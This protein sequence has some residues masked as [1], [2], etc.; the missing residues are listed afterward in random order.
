[1]I[2]TARLKHGD[3]AT[4][5]PRSQSDAD[6]ASRFIDCIRDAVAHYGEPRTRA[7][8]LRCCKG[9]VAEDWIAGVSDH[10][11]VLLRMSCNNWITILE[12]DFM[13][14]LASRLSAARAETFHWNLGRTPAEYVAKK[15]RLLRMANIVEDDEVVG[16]LHCGFAAAPNLHLH[17]DKYVVQAGN[18]V[19]E[20]HRAVVRLQDS[21]IRDGDAMLQPRVGTR[22]LPFRESSGVISSNTSQPHALATASACDAPAVPVGTGTLA[23]TAPRTT[24]KRPR[25]RLRKCKNYPECGDGEHSDWQCIIKRA[26]GTEIKRAYYADPLDSEFQAEDCDDVNELL[27]DNLAPQPELEEEYERAQ[28][29]YF[30]TSY[31][32]EAGLGFLGTLSSQ[33]TSKEPVECMNCGSTFTSNNKLHDHLRIHCRAE[34]KGSPE[35]PT[36]VKSA[37]QASL[38]PVEG[39]ADFHYAKTF[40]YTSPGGT[41]HMA[42]VDSGFGNSAV[43]DELQRRVYPKAERLPLP[44]PRVVEGLGG[45]ECTTTHVAILRI[46]MR[47][48]DGRFAELVR[49]FHIFKD[50]SVPL[51]IGNDIRKLEK[52]DPLY[53]SNRL[54]I[55]SCEGI[56]VQITVH[57]GHRFARIPVRCAAAI[58]IPSGTSTVVRI[59]L[60]RALEPNQ[61]YQFTPI[62]TRSAISGAG[63]P[64]SVLRHN[65]RE[66]LYTNFA[67]KPLTIFKGTVL[68]HVQSLESSSSLTWEDTSKDMKALF[69]TASDAVL[70]MSAM[71]IFNPHQTDSVDSI[72]AGKAY[73]LDPDAT[74]G[75]DFYEE[76]L[77][78]PAPVQSKHPVPD[79]EKPYASEIFKSAQWLEEEYVP[80]YEHVL[81]P[82]IKA[83]DTATSTWEQVVI[84]AEDDIA[85][86]KLRP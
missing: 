75:T 72:N 8:L 78:R 43:D 24:N 53:S 41:P 45:A 1:M 37:A 25:E 54:R 13:P 86:A 61:D 5:E 10:D 82:Y 80:R 69:G 58:V 34:G 49:P 52:F 51:L 42:C 2:P 83:P 26:T 32:H 57:A 6:S 84:N 46:F 9:S 16:E 15:L 63:A 73:T 48:T 70:A 44:R 19:S 59:K 28:N 64:Y 60:G 71:E 38:N 21:A 23:R 27:Y 30:A 12:R 40:W 74:T 56:P 47:G 66:L 3:V 77:P 17:L 55:G 18:S 81:P 67:E 4:F 65:K 36:I 11:R 29:A 35:Q 50:L 79:D 33:H 62:Q 39:L 31:R 14:Y 76:T 22:R 7:V 85:A 20:Y 68:G